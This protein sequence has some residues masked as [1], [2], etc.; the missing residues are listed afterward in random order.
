[1][2]LASSHIKNNNT[3]IQFN[4][5]HKQSNPKTRIREKKERRNTWIKRWIWNWTILNLHNVIQSMNWKPNL[6]VFWTLSSLSPNPKAKGKASKKSGMERCPEQKIAKPIKPQA[7]HTWHGRAKWH[8]R[9]NRHGQAVPH[10][11]PAW[12]A[13]LTVRLDARPCLRPFARF[14]LFIL[15]LLASLNLYSS[16]QSSQNAIFACEIRRF[17]LKAQKSHNI[18]KIA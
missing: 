10:C 11:W 2:N 5:H 13:V 9:A 7:L 6:S 4:N 12:R 3:N 14:A 15:M 17:S 8:G 1:M 18:S 16:P